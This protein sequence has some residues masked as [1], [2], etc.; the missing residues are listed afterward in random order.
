MDG[1]SVQDVEQTQRSTE[2]AAGGRAEGH[3]NDITLNFQQHLIRN[4]TKE[5]QSY[6]SFFLKRELLIYLLVVNRC[7]Y[8]CFKSLTIR[9]VS[10]IFKTGGSLQGVSVTSSI[11]SGSV[12]LQ[13][14]LHATTLDFVDATEA[15]NHSCPGT[16]S[17][18]EITVRDVVW[19]KYKF[20]SDYD[21]RKLNVDK[22]EENCLGLILSSMNKDNY[23]IGERLLFWKQWGTT[24][25]L[26]I[27][28][29]RTQVTGMVKKDCIQG[30]VQS[31]VFILICLY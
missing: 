3:A 27:A 13:K 11:S 24:V 6:V 1:D 19:S 21:M 31:D 28:Q 10:F 8:A 22:S 23:S 16:K 12:D 4:G 9:H 15:K 25:K 26:R 5:S 17:I 18:I 14:L 29:M 20:L 7:M 2:D 30:I